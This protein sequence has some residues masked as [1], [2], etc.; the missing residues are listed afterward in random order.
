[1]SIISGTKISINPVFNSTLE[2]QATCD[3]TQAEPGDGCWAL[4]DRCG[5]TQEELI[6][7]NRA[8]ICDGGLQV[9]DYICCSAGDL[10]DFS[11][12][13]NPDRS[14]KTYT[15]R[16]GNTC[17]PIANANSMTVEDIEDRNKNTWGWMGCQ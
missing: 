6:E 1:V 5:I 12:Q 7:H 2:K 3:Y 8:E 14:C 17:A 4:A 11:P 13:P 10:P 9:S 16:T 15:I